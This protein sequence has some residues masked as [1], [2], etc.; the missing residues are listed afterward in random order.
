MALI[1]T[2]RKDGTGDYTSIST[3]FT[4]MLASGVSE[5]GS[6]VEYAILVDSGFY[7]ESLSGYIPYSG[8]FTI[9]SSGAILDL[10]SAITVSGERPSPLIPNLEI[11]NFTIIASGLSTYIVNIDADFGISLKDIQ[12]I[13]D[14]Y[15]IYNSGGYLNIFNCESCATESGYPYFLSGSGIN[16]INGLH[17][18]NYGTGIY[19]T[20]ST[21]ENSI[22]NNNLTAI[23]SNNNFNFNINK[24]LFYNNNYAVNVGSG[25]LYIDNSTF[26]DPIYFSGGLVCINKII[27]SD[28][29]GISGGANYGSYIKNSCLYPAPILDT[30]ISGINN[31]NQDPLFNYSG[32]GDY[33]LQFQEV[34]G[35]PCIEVED[36]LDL[37]GVTISINNSM[38]QLFNDE[39]TIYSQT[40]LPFIYTQNSSIILSDYN[41][42]YKFA[43][44]IE[45]Y[46][47][48]TYKLFFNT[49]FTEYNVKTESSFETNQNL[50]HPYPWDWD[51]KTFNTTR[52]GYDETYIIPRSIV[53]IEDIIDSRLGNLKGTIFYQNL[54]SNNITVYD[55]I[56]YKGIC[57]DSFSSNSSESIIW[58]ID[59]NNQSLIK[60]NAF[61]GENIE[62][63]PLL[64]NVFPKNTYVKPSGLIYTGVNGDFYTFIK[65]DDPSIE[66]RGYS[67]QGDFQWLPTNL[68]TKYDIRGIVSYDTNLFITAGAYQDDVSSRYIMTSGNVDPYILMYKNNDLFYNYL[69]M[70][71]EEYG[72]KQFSLASGN[73]YPTDLTIYEDGSLLV[74]DYFSESGIFK[75]NLSYDYAIT[76]ISF[77]NETVIL[78][79]EYYSDVDL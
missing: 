22:F 26:D 67:E 54:N 5:S 25:N 73:Y 43:E 36:S 2:V 13:E 3:C 18:S 6:I 33:R 60:Q 12:L 56:N 11:N 31:I 40:V 28:P 47:D 39:K 63:Y 76:K 34:T 20:D 58:I 21:I 46:N 7:Q 55:Q 53:N 17:I 1:K 66:V 72:P 4:E 45:Y 19:V 37:S 52:I 35:S 15:G 51:I 71:N 61:T 38:L 68:N 62:V 32:I 59:G 29:I 24:S 27:V 78:L 8:I 48:I 9:T 64:V 42:E 79:R 69:K 41:K 50:P 14:G 44:L 70:P 57:Y 74:A 75:Y 49:L 23:Y 30:N 16:S 10:P 65:T 77:D